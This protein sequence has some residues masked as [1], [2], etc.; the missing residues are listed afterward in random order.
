[1]SDIASN[2]LAISVRKLS[3]GIFYFRVGCTQI[4]PPDDSFRT[5]VSPR[6][7][8]IIPRILFRG[9]LYFAAPAHATVYKSL[10]QR[11]R[12]K[13]TLHFQSINRYLDARCT[14]IFASI[15]DELTDRPTD[16]TNSQRAYM[17]TWHSN[18]L[19]RYTLP[20]S[21]SLKRFLVFFLKVFN[22]FYK[23]EQQL[24]L[25][26]NEARGQYTP[27]QNHDYTLNDSQWWSDRS[28]SK[29]ATCGK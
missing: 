5:E 3:P 13:E 16:S 4:H 2:E 21:N 22:F 28:T 14:P 23:T 11:C 20:K 24:K 9:I 19:Y 18:G 27:K 25:T 1:M 15:A 8:Y 7:E 29:T 12:T 26:A 6:M 17:N 10:K